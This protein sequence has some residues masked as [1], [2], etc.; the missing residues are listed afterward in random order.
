MAKGGTVD[1][2][3]LSCRCVA[4]AVDRSGEAARLDKERGAALKR[5]VDACIAR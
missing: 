3:E 5:M 4:D 2:C 1:D